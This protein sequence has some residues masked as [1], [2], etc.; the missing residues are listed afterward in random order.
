MNEFDVFVIGTGTA[1]ETAASML[2]EAGLTVGIADRGAFG[3]TCALRGCQPKKYLVVPAHAA[4][5]GAGLTER[6]FVDAPTLD[7]AAMQRSRAE[8][9]DAVPDGTVMGLEEKGIPV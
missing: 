7:W 8:F 5:E 3:G 9:T 2:R 4:M 1:G 6:G